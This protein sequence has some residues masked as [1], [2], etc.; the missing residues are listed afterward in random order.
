MR[1]L[2]LFFLMLFA[3][4]GPATAQSQAQNENMAV[5]LE[6][7]P[8]VD[9]KRTV[10]LVM[11]P[12]E[13]WHTYWKN[14]GAAGVETRVEW[15]LPPGAAASEIRY[16]VPDR[17]VVS[18]IMNYVFET[19]RAL[20][21]DIS[22][23]PDTGSAPVAVRI[24]YLVCDDEI[25]IP[26]SAELSANLEDV[27]VDAQRLAAWES[28]QPVPAAG[29]A[30]FTHT[31]EELRIAADV[32]DAAQVSAAYFF[33]L[34]DGAL[35]YNA[36]Q[37]AGRDGDRIVVTAAPSFR[38]DFET[39]PGVLKLQLAGGETLGLAI[40]AVPGDVPAASGALDPAAAPPASSG[41]AGG[42]DAI[43]LGLVFLAALL[44]GVLLNVMPC[45][46]PILSL[47]ALSLAKGGQSET[48][49]RSEAL[50]YSAGVLLAVL[51]LGA[52]LLLLRGGGA[53]VGWAFQLQDP[54]VVFLLLLLV[55]AIALNLAGLFELPGISVSG[56]GAAARGGH[57]GAFMTGV[58]AAIVATPC[59]GPFM[60]AALGAALVVEGAGA[61]LIFA[62]LGLGLALPFLLIGFI[63]ALRRRLPKPG[64]WM[65]RARK[66]LSLPMFATAF[67][68]AWV[69]GRQA[70]VEG[71][72][73][74]IGGVLLLGLALWWF[75]G[76]R[77]RMVPAAAAFLSLFI[78]LAVPADGEQAAAATESNYALAAEPFSAAR[79]DELQS[80]GTPTFVYFTAD[81]CITCKVNERGALSNGTV[82]EHFRAQGIETLVG[83]WTRPDPAIT[84]F[85]TSKGRA[86]VPLY[87]FYA[88]DGSETI[89]PQ[90]LTVDEL[91]SLGVSG[92]T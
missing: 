80:A 48:A 29:S 61:L 7:G 92:K 57:S 75:G 53:S 47:K 62:G 10:A 44:G 64:A 27:T 34:I 2:T 37:Q 33:P 86:G 21:V 69:L 71:L 24:D 17:F 11:T 15:Q 45:V 43:P 51:A 36:P 59:T 23:L 87:L 3:A 49:A 20:L 68:L 4:N 19:E 31:G 18:G 76:S 90:L 40:E 30:R 78:V 73:A 66:L 72:V 1:F 52:T 38:S 32:P 14:P 9:G 77:H 67:G 91:L 50:F 82:A 54:R 56:D 25:C 42:G 5:A 85:L 39:L 79:L 81:W 6:A 88:G 84:A 70:G 22:G 28:D 8:H 12:R 46:F 65:E 26:E 74:G 58:L 16:P 55:S 83:D 63:P 35:D 13:G 41:P 89:L 60:G